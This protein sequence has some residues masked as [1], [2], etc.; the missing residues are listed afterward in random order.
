MEWL[1]ISIAGGSRHLGEKHRST[2]F[3]TS[4]TARLKGYIS[5]A[6]SHVAQM[7]GDESGKANPLKYKIGLG[8][9]LGV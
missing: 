4:D 1:L 7:T 2:S 3:A 6:M 9:A 5:A 8:R